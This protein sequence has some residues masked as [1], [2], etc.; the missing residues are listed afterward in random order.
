[1]TIKESIA[2]AD[3]EQ[4]LDELLRRNALVKCSAT[5]LVDGRTLAKSK[6]EGLTSREIEGHLEVRALEVMSRSMATAGRGD[7]VYEFTLAPARGD[8]APGTLTATVE[9]LAVNTK[10]GQ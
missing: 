4:L 9:M 5:L 8:Y 2:R 3:T 10:V 6:A 7:R 1:M